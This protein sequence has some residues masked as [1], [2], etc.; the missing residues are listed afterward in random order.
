[1]VFPKT[2][3]YIVLS[4]IE[5]FPSNFVRNIEEW[6]QITFNNAYD[7]KWILKVN[8]EVIPVSRTFRRIYIKADRLFIS[9]LHSFHHKR[10]LDVKNIVLV[11]TSN[12]SKQ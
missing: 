4:L 12:L 1:M 9:A 7:N 3:A 10:V 5:P 11:L 8:I 6:E 2:T